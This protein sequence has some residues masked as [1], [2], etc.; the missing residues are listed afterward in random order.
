M[1]DNKSNIDILFT[2]YNTEEKILKRALTCL[3]NIDNFILIL[4]DGSTDLYYENLMLMCKTLS[5]KNYRV[6]RIDNNIGQYNATNYG[7]KLLNNE[8]V[9]RLD[10]DDTFFDIPCN[11]LSGKD[12]YSPFETCRNLKEW[13]NL[14]NCRVSGSI[15][16]RE[17][18]SIMYSSLLDKKEL[19]YFHEDVYAFLTLFLDE[20]IKDL[21]QEYISPFYRV[22][23][24]RQSLKVPK[25]KKINNRN[26]LLFYACIKQGKS[27]GFYKKIKGD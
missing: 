11:V 25:G 16:K 8:Y 12:F 14:K 15:I 22:M 19:Y 13:V 26:N 4:L 20:R 5:L 3:V 10:D 27:L 24:K 23:N 18:M 17:V 7:L 9:M 21:S 1:N 2:T 6:V